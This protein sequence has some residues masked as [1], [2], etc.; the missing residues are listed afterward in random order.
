MQLL[1]RVRAATHVIASSSIPETPNVLSCVDVTV[2]HFRNWGQA[3]EIH[4]GCG[5]KES[6]HRGKY[7]FL[8]SLIG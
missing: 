6:L 4:V 8:L 7:S 2:V 1:I 3:K 5:W